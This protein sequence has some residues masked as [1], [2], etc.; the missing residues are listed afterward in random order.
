M[1]QMFLRGTKPIS[2]LKDLHNKLNWTLIKPSL[3][4]SESTLYVHSSTSAPTTIFVSLK[5]IARMPSSTVEVI[6][7][8]TCNNLKD[9]L[10]PI[11]LTSRFCSTKHYMN[12][13]K[14]HVYGTYFDQKLL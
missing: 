9:S 6:S 10:T 11:I 7:R 2:S 4:S 14:L 8:Y 1:L 12:S 5:S 13:S 3:P